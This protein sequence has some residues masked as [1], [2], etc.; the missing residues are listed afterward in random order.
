VKAKRRPKP[1]PKPGLRLPLLPRL[2][3]PFFRLQRVNLP[4]QL[5]LLRVALIPVFI[6]LFLSDDVRLQ[7][8]G[9]AVFVLSAIT[10]YFDG[11]IARDRGQITN[12]GKVMDPLADKLLMLTAMISFVQAGLVP[13]WMI[14]VIWWRE[15]AVTGLRTLVAARSRILA[16]DKWGKIKTVL[17]AVAVVVGM[18]VYCSQN[19]LNAASADWRMQLEN[20]GWWGDFWA[21]LLDTNALAYW[22]MFLAAVV[23][24]FS[25]IRYFRV[26]W[27]IVCEEL[28]EAERAE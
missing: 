24:L 12:F 14:T 16:A 25:G 5:T 18:L 10:D 4:N 11:K 3:F 26:N 13:G 2:P 6:T 27:E 7:W 23:S 9:F 19:T 15:L 20:S 22:L 28:E 8:G 17:Q 21:R 1:L